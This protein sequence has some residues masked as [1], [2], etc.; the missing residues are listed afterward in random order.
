MTDDE[1]LA[2]RALDLRVSAAR[3]TGFVVWEAGEAIAALTSRAELADWLYERL[4]SIPGEREREARD[5]AA[6]EA[7]LGN[8]ERFPN[9]ARP[10]TDPPRR[11][12]RFFGSE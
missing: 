3:D 7:A 9:V 5:L 1:P 2:K 8:V 11:R 6:T 4:G 12:S 10:R